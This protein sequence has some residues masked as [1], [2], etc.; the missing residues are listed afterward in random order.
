MLCQATVL[1]M[2]HEAHI[3][4]PCERQWSKLLDAAENAAGADADNL[5]NDMR[6]VYII[7]N[8]GTTETTNKSKIQNT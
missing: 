8:D 5:E 2:V 6:G 1:I 7:T 3:R 4:N